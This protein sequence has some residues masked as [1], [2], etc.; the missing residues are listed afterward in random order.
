MIIDWEITRDLHAKILKIDQ[1]AYI[2]N[3]LKSEEMSSCY[4]TIL[5][6]KVSSTVPMDQVG[7]DA[8]VDLTLYQ[9]LVGKLMYLVCKT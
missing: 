2:Q 7:N 4:P 1:K 8:I 5:P 3:F 6:M 9:R